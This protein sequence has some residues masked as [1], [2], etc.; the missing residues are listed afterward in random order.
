M[1]KEFWKRME[2]HSSF[3]FWTANKK[4][5]KYFTVFLEKAKEVGIRASI[6]TLDLAAW[7]ERVD[8]YDFDMTWAAWGSGI[9]KDPESQWLSKYA[10]EAGQPNL[11]G[12]KIDEVDKLIENKNGIFCL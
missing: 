9:F 10:D 3:L 5:E 7:S 12:L 4:T 1:L 6:D 2:N 8:K 11:P